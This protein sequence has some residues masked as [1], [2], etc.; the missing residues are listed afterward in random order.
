MMVGLIIGQTH[1]E[2]RVLL[3]SHGPTNIRG[4]R[5]E[6][7]AAAYFKIVESIFES[8]KAPL[9]KPGP[10]SWL[11]REIHDLIFYLSKRLEYKN[12]GAKN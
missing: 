5:P 2:K 8:T 3:Q 9:A 4:P 12:E 1:L 6:E 7:N 11:E 10:L